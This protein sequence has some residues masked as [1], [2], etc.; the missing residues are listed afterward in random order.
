MVIG[1]TNGI[2]TARLLVAHVIA[3]V[4]Q[5]VAELRC[6]AVDVVH[7]WYALTSLCL[8]VWI[9][10][11]RSGRTLALG[12]VVI[13]NADSM[14]AALD[15]LASRSAER[16]SVALDTSLRLGTFGMTGA[17]TSQLRSASVSVVRVAVVSA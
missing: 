16:Y 14:R 8:I 17:S 9:A 11:E 6:W 3:R 7:T 1:D 15:L 5:S 2:L 12:V 10:G 13:R 4:G